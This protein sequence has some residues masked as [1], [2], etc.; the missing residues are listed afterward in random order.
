M[1]VGKEETRKERESGGRSTRQNY[2]TLAHWTMDM[3][4][5]IKAILNATE[6]YVH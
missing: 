6:I 5:N 1:E 4:H 2:R 3:V